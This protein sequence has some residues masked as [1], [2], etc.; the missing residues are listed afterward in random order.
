MTPALQL[1]IRAMALVVA[2]HDRE[3]R[4]A[5][6]AAAGPRIAAAV[7]IERDREA[8]EAALAA[9]VEAIGAKP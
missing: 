3:K 1:A 9:A 2:E 6:A 7:K 8:G 5:L 4:V